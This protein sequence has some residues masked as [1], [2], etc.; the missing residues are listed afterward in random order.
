MIATNGRYGIAWQL[1]RYPKRF[2]SLPRTVL[3]SFMRMHENT[4]FRENGRVPDGLEHHCASSRQLVASGFQILF[5]IYFINS[6]GLIVLT[7]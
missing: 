1:Q 4:T 7:V 6:I 5:W 2:L 3:A